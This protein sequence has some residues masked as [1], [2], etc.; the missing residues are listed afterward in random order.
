M[1]KLFGIIISVFLLAPVMVQASS[2]NQKSQKPIASWT[3][4]DFLALD[5]SFQPTAVGFTEALN[6]KGNPE[7]AVIDFDGI[8][9]VTPQLIEECTK[10]KQDNFKE[11]AK[12]LWQRIK[13]K[14]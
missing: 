2:D 14:L 10:N 1:N 4:E 8:E 5:S 6:I 11:K 13:Q 7:D 3:C 12:N 9:T